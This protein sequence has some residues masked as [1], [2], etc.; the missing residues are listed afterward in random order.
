MS[1]RRKR[2]QDG[3]IRR[4]KPFS[5]YSLFPRRW[6]VQSKEHWL[7]LSRCTKRDRRASERISEAS[8][9]R[10]PAVSAAS[11]NSIAARPPQDVIDN[12]GMVGLKLSQCLGYR[13]V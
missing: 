10:P 7:K 6:N 2:V 11:M 8:D 13:D 5:S 1:S 12:Q 4:S 3:L 9:A